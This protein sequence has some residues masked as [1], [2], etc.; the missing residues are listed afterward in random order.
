MSAKIAKIASVSRMKNRSRMVGSSAGG[1]LVA[2]YLEASGQCH[3]EPGRNEDSDSDDVSVTGPAEL[4]VHVNDEA[5][6]HQVPA[7]RNQE[8]CQG[9]APPADD[10]NGYCHDRQLGT[11]VDALACARDRHSDA[12][13]HA[14]RHDADE[15]VGQ[16]RVCGAE[17]TTVNREGTGPA[18]RQRQHGVL[19]SNR[20]PRGQRIQ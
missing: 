19:L 1:K 13:S 8:T 7:Q 5:V 15:C 9:A 10:A 6:Q 14:E 20:C 2:L 11:P 16:S 17:R 4:A 12:E 18:V 3:S